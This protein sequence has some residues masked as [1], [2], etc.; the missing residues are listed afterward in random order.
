MISIQIPKIK[1]FSFIQ[2]VVA[3][4]LI[5]FPCK[6]KQEFNQMQ[7]VVERVFESIVSSSLV[8]VNLQSESII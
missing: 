5:Q 4:D 7:D 2:P 8:L 6:E 3:L 1:R